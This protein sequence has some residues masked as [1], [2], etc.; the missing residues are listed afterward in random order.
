[1]IRTKLN[2]SALYVSFN[3]FPV[4]ALLYRITEGP[5][6]IS[7]VVN[8]LVRWCIYFSLLS[9]LQ[10]TMISLCLA[11]LV[12]PKQGQINIIINIIMLLGLRYEVWDTTHIECQTRKI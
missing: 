9:K 4:S 2:S 12:K 5:I 11:Q 10:C 3:K 7:I 1:M 8:V 6:F